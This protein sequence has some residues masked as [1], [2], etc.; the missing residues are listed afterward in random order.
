MHYA[1]P[2]IPGFYPDP[3]VCRAG[4]D[5]YLVTSTFEYF[6]GV[7]IFHSQDLIHWR[8]IG[9]CLT[10][11][12]Q[13]PLAHI[14]SS[15]GI[16]APTIRYHNGVFYMV[17]T[18]VS[19]GKHFYVTADDPA[20]DWSEPIWINR[21]GIDPSLFFDDDG[22]VYFTWVTRN[23]IHQ[24]EID[25]LTGQSLTSDRL[26]WSGSGG[27]YPE[28]PHLYKINGT[29]YLMIAEGGTEFGHMETIARS[30]SPWGPF[31]PCPRN[32][33]LTH[34]NLGA[35]RIQA[36]GHADLI[37]AHDGSWWTVFLGFRCPKQYYGYH[38]LGRE[39][40]L[41][42][43]D[44][45]ND[46]WP[47]VYH[48]GT[49]DEEMEANC[50]PPH[51]WEQEPDRDD[52]D[53]P[54]LRFCWNFLRN[55]YPEDWSLSE[56]PG[57]LRLKGSAVT[58]NASDS[59]AFV[60]RRQQHFACRAAA[61]LDFSPQKTGDEAGLTILMNENHHYEI[62][63]TVRDGARWVFVRRRIG[64]LMAEVAGEPIPAGLV[65]LQIQADVE[66]YTFSYVSGDQPPRTMLTCSARYL[67]S[68]VAGGFTGVYI[69]MYATGNGKTAAS[70]ADFDWFDYKPL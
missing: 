59:P 70:P 55:P 1:N 20:G 45:D 39:T 57:W 13:L 56:R 17:T 29:Y 42:P 68:E 8:Q 64:D 61:L 23:A 21:D 22:K 51:V 9:H 43:V 10:R 40:F 52:F 38:H 15:G 62:G 47:I 60:G 6:P 7:P 27:R 12:S 24:Q 18:N 31:E 49:V 2:V 41:A 37:Q 16:Y 28:A 53:K 67:S 46:G 4:N 48:N 5:Y 63:I 33:I 32:P 44:W 36:T 35:H 58:L 66:H 54:I 14:G 11:A 50:L 26:I 34:R 3:S 25:I 19:A 30:D 69:G 65:E